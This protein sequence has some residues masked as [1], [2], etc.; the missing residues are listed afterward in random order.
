MKIAMCN[1]MFNNRPL[2]EQFRFI[3]Q[4]GYNG[5]EIAPF[6]I[7]SDMNYADPPTTDVRQLDQKARAEIVKIAASEGIAISG[8]HW[9]LAKTNA[10]FHLTS[11][12][13]D[14]RRK[15]AEYFKELAYF[16][17]DLGGSYMVLGSPVERN[18]KPKVRMYEAYN[19]A[20]DVIAQVLPA[21]EQ[22]KV[23]LA[24]EPL[25]PTETNFLQTG[26]DA[27]FLIE[28]LGKPSS[29]AIHFDCKAMTG[30]E[31]KPIAEVLTDPKYRPY[32]KTFH[33]NDPNLRG[34][35]FGDLDMKPIM[36]ALKE[37][38]FDGWIGVEPF[39]YTATIERLARES[40]KNLKKFL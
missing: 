36:G 14:V 34:P 6:S 19:Y 9:L 30:S 38:K 12:E 17:R 26:E 3:A 11:P 22:T 24:F 33:A 5:V 4:C 20:A 32:I 27:L 29:L 7:A 13:K 8:L 37:I 18:L 35:G 21:L 15:T 16:C 2:S 25:A 40:I 39:D 28:K 1:E 10:G 31:R 23:T